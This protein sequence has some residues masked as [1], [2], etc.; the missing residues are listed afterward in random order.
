MR[1]IRAFFRF[2][3]S[4][5]T[6]LDL[7]D[8]S[9]PNGGLNTL[10]ATS[11]SGKTT[12]FKLLAGWFSSNPNCAVLTEPQIN[13]P[14]EVRLVGVQSSLLPWLTVQGNAQLHLNNGHNLLD[15]LTEVG[16]NHEVSTMYPYQLSLGMAKRVEVVLAVLSKPKL[17]L[18]DEVFES[19][20]E[21]QKQSLREFICRQRNDALTWVVTHE[22]TVAEF[23]GG[24]R[25]SFV[26]S[27]GIVVG[28]QRP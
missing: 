9:L 15:E 23:L 13:H 18:L 7:R 16:L 2:A 10:M 8:C 3:D 11:G 20:D 17:L 5:R 4:G 6:L 12:L 1:I 24:E 25:L 22:P 14:R 19:V 28:L 26:C 21:T 27:E